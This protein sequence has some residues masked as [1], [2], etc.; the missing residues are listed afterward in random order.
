MTGEFPWMFSQ[1]YDWSLY[2]NNTRIVSASALK[3]YWR[4]NKLAKNY[5]ILTR[6]LN[7]NKPP[8]HRDL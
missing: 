8:S 5:N 6:I 7:T 4:S 3:Q 1:A 2:I